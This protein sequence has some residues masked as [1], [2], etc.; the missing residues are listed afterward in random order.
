MTALPVGS[1]QP[2]HFV[3]RADGRI[4]LATRSGLAW[5]SGARREK[6]AAAVRAAADGLADEHACGVDGAW[7]RVVR[8][9]AAVTAYI[10]VLDG[11]VP[12]TTV[13]RSD[14]VLTPR[15][16]EIAEYAIRGATSG[17]I[18]R[19]LAISQATVRSHLKAIYTRLGV[20][21]RVELANALRD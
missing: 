14:A 11:A 9:F 20:C 5:L 3:A 2:P 8:V 1:G 13:L 7:V 15:Q 16:R 10:V 17:E 6:L 12:S 4:E 21:S 18:A 19:T